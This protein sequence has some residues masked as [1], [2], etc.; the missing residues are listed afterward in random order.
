MIDPVCP[1]KLALYGH[2]D[3]GTDWEQ[4]SHDHVVSQGFIPVDNWPS[5]YWHPEHKL[6]LVI[7]VDDFKL[8]GPADKLEEGWRLISSGL[9]IED[10]SPLGMFLGCKHEQSER[11]LP[12]SSK[13]VR[14]MEYNMEEFLRSCVDRYKELTGV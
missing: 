11:I 4:H 12:G 14:V 6:F 2:P 10:P 13:R 1:L 7:Y 3:F 8:S 5:C 9:N